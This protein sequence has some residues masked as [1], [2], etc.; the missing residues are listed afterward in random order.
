MPPGKR[1]SSNVRVLSHMPVG[2]PFTGSDIDIEQELSRP[3]AYVPTFT[4][5]GLNI[6]DLRDPTRASVIYQWRIENPELHQFPGALNSKYFKLKGKYYSVIGVQFGRNGPDADLGAIVLDVTGL[7]N[8]STVHEAGRIRVPDLPGGFHN[9]FTYKHST[10]T[11]L[12]FSTVGARPTT[13][14]GANIYDM[15]RFLAGAADQGL[16]GGVPLPEPRGAA[17]GYH[18]MY[19]AY[20]PAT[21]QDKFYGGGPEVTMQGG[22]YVYDVTDVRTP[23]LILSMVGVAGHTGG[24]TFVASPDGRY[25]ITWSAVDYSPFRFFDL[26]PALTGEVKNIT[27]PIG[28]WT[29]DWKDKGHNAEIRWPYVFM[30]TYEDGMQVVNM[31]DPTNPYT[32]GY[33]DT[34]DGPH[35]IQSWQTF[36]N[37]NGPPVPSA[38]NGAF[39]VDVRNADGLIVINDMRTGFWAL[40]MDGFDGWNGHQWGMPNISSAQDWD[41]GPEGVPKPARVS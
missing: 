3:Y 12:L 25:G 38:S 5:M 28:A 23:K 30:A 11:A 27:R 16:V 22:Y 24:H 4:Q 35:A 37:P 14:Q 17:D 36:R 39:G 29:P 40:K 18:D 10:G 7:P 1:G 19:V 32:V 21:H 8:P 13:P 15:E 33:W 2:G 31:M 26:R 34:Y 9:I 20:D 6:V 41:N